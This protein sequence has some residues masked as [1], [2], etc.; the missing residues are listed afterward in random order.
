M[1]V[2]HTNITVFALAILCWFG[3]LQPNAAATEREYESLS[4]QQDNA[5]HNF[6]VELADTHE[7][8]VQGLMHRLTLEPHEGM[9]FDFKTEQMISMWMYK[10]YLPLDMLFIDSDGS[11]VHI[12]HDATPL[13]TQKIP[14]VKPAR[15]VLEI[16]GGIA[17]EL[18]IMVGDRI[19]HPLFGTDN[20]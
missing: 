12:A 4:I 5:I 11:I 7:K 16:N 9:L 8:R 10:T 13:S 17:K 15:A 18:G 6:Q 2:S 3:L 1:L 14:S 19:L 20:E